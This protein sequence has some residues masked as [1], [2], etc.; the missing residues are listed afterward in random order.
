MMPVIGWVRALE[1][2]LQSPP[3]LWRFRRA[4]R[5]R[6]GGQEVSTIADTETP[7]CLA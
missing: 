4:H 1:D 5:V 6:D 3:D 7:R 2:A